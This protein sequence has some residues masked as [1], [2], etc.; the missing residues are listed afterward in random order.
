MELL[1]V[2]AHARFYLV[3]APRAARPLVFDMIARLA[4]RGDLQVLDGGNCFNAYLCSRNLARL[5][6]FLPAESSLTLESALKRIRVARAF[7]CYQMQAMLHDTPPAS[8]PTLALDLLSTFYDE[9]VRDE[10][11][12]RLLRSCVDRLL[13][14]SRRAP[15]VITASP[16]P[17][18]GSQRAGLLEILQAAAAEIWTVEDSSPVPP[19]MTLPL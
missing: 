5:V 6:R 8:L 13:E 14:L 10:E 17:P 4:L 11:S 2:P 15:V 18:K 9:N 19:Q 7:T 12:T 1:P 16:G 3:V